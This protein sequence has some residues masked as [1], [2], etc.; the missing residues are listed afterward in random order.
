MKI[1]TIAIS[2]YNKQNY[3][4]RCIKSLI[5]E[6]INLLEIIIVNDGSTDRTSDIAHLLEK[7]YPESII[8]IDKENEHQGSCINNAIKLATGKYFKMLDADDYFS[9]EVLDNVITL[10]K[11][12]DVDMIVSG[13][14]IHSN[15]PVSIL[16]KNIKEN[17]IYNHQDTDFSK[18]GMEKC[19]GMHG[20][21]F[22]TKILKENQIQLTEKCSFSDAEYSYYP[23]KYCKTIIFINQNLYIYQ[24][25]V[26]GQESSLTSEKV[27]NDA[28]RICKRMIDDYIDNPTLAPKIKRNEEVILDR[29]LKVY[30]GLY[31]LHFKTNKKDNLQIDELLD[32]CKEKVP[33][34]YYQVLK[35]HTR[36]IPFVYIY[37][38]TKKTSHYLFKILNFIYNLIK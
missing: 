9:T 30:F 13:H 7:S 3:I 14:L 20:V 33:Y 16:P 6:N 23:L 32:I 1:L 10:L 5:C 22:R 2:A 15:E 24:T 38:K 17:I 29:C 21:A 35:T 11:N 27:K 4:E 31:L 19:L 12:T 26:Q 8:V 18:L 37:K 28:Y 25:G 36:K 34:I